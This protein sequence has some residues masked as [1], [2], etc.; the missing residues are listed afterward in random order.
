M[1]HVL[2][3]ENGINALGFRRK[4]V[5][6]KLQ[7]VAAATCS[8][9]GEELTEHEILTQMVPPNTATGRRVY[10]QRCRELGVTPRNGALQ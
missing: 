6:G 1:A 10:E 9:C 2:R 5:D 7:Y 4:E 8:D 3:K